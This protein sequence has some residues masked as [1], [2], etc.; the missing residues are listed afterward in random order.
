MHDKQQR[1]LLGLL[2]LVEMDS[3]TFS[4]P[5]WGQNGGGGG[6]GGGSSSKGRK[7]ILMSYFH[8]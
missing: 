8:F 2:H 4:E 1:V 6:G 5:L 7:A 3:L